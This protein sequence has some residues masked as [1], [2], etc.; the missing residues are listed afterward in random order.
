MTDLHHRVLILAESS[1]HAALV[2]YALEREVPAECDVVNE[3]QELVTKAAPD[4]KAIPLVLI[5][6]EWIAYERALSSL[7]SAGGDT[8]H[9]HFA[10]YNL[11][12]HSSADREALV[13]G[14]RG[15][16]YRR[17]SLELFVKGSVSILEGDTWVSRESLLRWVLNPSSGE[18]PV[19][20][21]RPLLTRREIEVLAQVSSGARNDEI[22]DRL[23][24]SPHTVKTHL[25][26]IYKKIG[27]PNRLQAALWAAKNL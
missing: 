19:S 12:S 7:R 6:A 17:D 20:T 18:S 10:V 27:V 11:D 21:D 8:A 9:Y 14:V 15:F 4:G 26:K 16:F 25:Y 2:A 3:P 24:I 1:L 23:F 22:A 13:Q 5:D